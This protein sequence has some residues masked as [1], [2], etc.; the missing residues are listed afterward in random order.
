MTVV[1]VDDKTL[2]LLI[3]G[4]K[5][6]AVANDGGQVVGYFAPALSREEMAR[7]HLGLPDPEELRRQGEKVEKTYTTAE[8]KAHLRSLEKR[9]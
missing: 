8:V 9:G 3:A 6:V 1:P 2:A 5:L 7:R 4:N